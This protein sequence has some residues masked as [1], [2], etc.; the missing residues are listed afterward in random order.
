M[1]ISLMQSSMKN[2]SFLADGT[3]NIIS[4]HNIEDLVQNCASKFGEVNLV[5]ADGSID[6]QLNPCEQEKMVVQLHF[7]EIVTTL[8]ILG[9]GIM[10]LSDIKILKSSY[11][12]QLK[13]NNLLCFRR[14]LGAE[15]IHVSG[16]T[17]NLTF[18]FTVVSISSYAF[19]SNPLQA[20]R[21][22]LKST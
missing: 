11:A 20:K 2:W 21:V 17:N 18:I 16:S 15:N 8:S 9:R 22:T 12:I 14:L 5:T 7:A 1:M 6:C 4:Q 10:N 3:G 13:A 19:Y